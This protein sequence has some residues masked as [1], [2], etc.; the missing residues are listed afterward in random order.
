[1]EKVSVNGG[2]G[3]YQF[4]FVRSGGY[5][6]HKCGLDRGGDY[7][8]L[9]YRVTDYGLPNHQV[10]DVC[11]AGRDGSNNMNAMAV[12]FRPIAEQI[13][14][15]FPNGVSAVVRREEVGFWFF[16]HDLT[17]KTDLWGTGVESSPSRLT[18]PGFWTGLAGTAFADGF[19]AV[20]LTPDTNWW[21]FKGQQTM[22][23][24]DTGELY[25]EAAGLTDDGRWPA[26]KNTKLQD[27]VDAVLVDGTGNFWFFKDGYCAQTNPEGTELLKS[28]RITDEGFWPALKGT[29]CE[30]GIDTV[31][32]YATY[33]WFF[34]ANQCLSTDYDG[35]EIVEKPAALTAQDRWPA[36]LHCGVNIKQ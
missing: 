27:A 9:D 20:C 16:R 2:T 26:L 1:M 7:F 22:A 31:Y 36:L 14:N 29:V 3:V 11:C 33:Y 19:D 6:S 17:V 12:S 25:R 13:G 15:G 32:Y 30:T 4:S 24:H 21:F 18:D 35:T 23:T 34:R 10:A 28:G 8:N 5:R